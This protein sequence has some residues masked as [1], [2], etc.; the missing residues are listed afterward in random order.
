VR[1][2]PRALILGTGYAGTRHAEALR[3]LGVA[4]SGPLS[5]RDAARDPSPT[6]DAGI[7]V[8][9]VC[10]ANDLHAPLV[11]AALDAGKHVVCEKP[12]AL[13]AAT[14]ADLAARAERAGVLATLGYGYRFLPMVVELVARI[15]AGELGNIHDARGSFLQDWLLLPTDQDWRVDPARGGASR[16]VADIGAHWLDLTELALGQPAVAVVAHV[17]RLHDRTTEDHAA[18]LVRFEGGVVAACVLSQAAAGHRND[19]QIAFDGSA[20]SLSWSYE[21]VDELS[22]GKRGRLSTVSRGDGLAS[23]HARRLAA[24]PGGPNEGRRNLLD[25]VYATLRGDEAPNAVPL[26]TFRDGVRHLRLAAAA[27]ESARRSAWV[28]VG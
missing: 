28:E 27:L 26:A 3:A 24:R 8:V 21:R 15:R 19:L 17:G 11:R 5:A 7:D 1:R 18:M 6:A 9:H 25:A 14:A 16:V 22:V 20:E 23:A 13:D 2:Q 12:L 4:F 10:S